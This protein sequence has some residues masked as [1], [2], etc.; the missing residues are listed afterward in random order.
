MMIEFNGQITQQNQIDRLKRVSK[1]ETILF[2]TAP[3]ALWVIGITVGLVFEFLQDIWL[4]MLICSIIIWVCAL[5]NKII[6]QKRLMRFRLSP[7]II[8]TDE[9]LSLELENRG[10]KVWR[11]RKLSKVKKVLDSGEVYYIIFKFGDITS[12][13][14]C[15]KDNIV[16]GTIEE[17][18]KLFEDKIQRKIKMK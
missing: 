12:A 1:V 13:W 8:I 16:N 9:E 15:Q 5:L 2:I 6:P 14:T 3:I 4:E 7:H 11:K 18:E 17:F 10:E